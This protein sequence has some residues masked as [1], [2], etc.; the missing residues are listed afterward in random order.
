MT[1]AGLDDGTIAEYVASGRPLDKAGGYAIQDEDVPTVHSL[2]GCYCGVMGLPLWL[3]RGLLQ[4]RG[5]SCADPS[6]TFPR[7]AVCPERA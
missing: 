5:I 7:C 1:L 4:A 3:T 2:E 6:A